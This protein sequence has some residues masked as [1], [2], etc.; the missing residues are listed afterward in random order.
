MTSPFENL[1]HKGTDLIQE[2]WFPALA[3][4]AVSYL[5]TWM[6][7]TLNRGWAEHTGMQS[8]V[9]CISCNQGWEDWFRCLIAA[10]SFL[11]LSVSH[12]YVTAHP[13][14]TPFIEKLEPGWK[15]RGRRGVGGLQLRGGRD[16]RETYT[17]DADGFLPNPCPEQGPL[18]PNNLLL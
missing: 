15:K 4:L 10:T 1:K 12:K 11:F 6:N 7:K 5:W 13:P 17:Q 3:G 14:E 18:S 9:I 8:K 2:S 16:C